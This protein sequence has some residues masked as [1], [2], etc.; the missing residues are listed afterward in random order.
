[1]RAVDI[2]SELDPD[3]GDLNLT[4]Y[5]DVVMNLVVFLMVSFVAVGSL[6][7]IPVEAPATCAGCEG[8]AEARFGLVLSLAASGALIASSDGSV[9]SELLP[10]PLDPARLTEALASWK[11]RYQLDDRLTVHANPELPVQTV[12]AAID[13]AREDGGAPLFPT[14]RLARG[15]LDP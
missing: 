3:E 2:R 7:V 14:P 10:G 12:V 9:P 8:G 5:L 4:P 15:L 13:A 1:M 11:Q 6:R